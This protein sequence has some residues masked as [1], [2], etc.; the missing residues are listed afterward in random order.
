MPPG[1][2]VASAVR[3]D[4]TV[5]GPPLIVGTGARGEL[6]RREQAG[7]GRVGDGGEAHRR[8]SGCGELI[9]EHGPGGRVHALIARPDDEGPAATVFLLHGGPGGQVTDRGEVKGVLEIASPEEFWSASK[10]LIL[11]QN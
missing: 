10:F 11:V 8:R 9:G 2:P 4:P 6:P 5:A 7:G 3:G 1:Q